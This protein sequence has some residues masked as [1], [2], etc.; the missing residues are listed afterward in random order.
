MHGKAEHS[1]IVIIWLVSGNLVSSV[2]VG[3]EIQLAICAVG[4]HQ[5]YEHNRS[6]DYA[7]VDCYSHTKLCSKH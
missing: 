2:V 6:V 5:A 1:F 3:M 4:D 7:L